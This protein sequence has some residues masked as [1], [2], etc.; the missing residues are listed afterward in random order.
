MTPPLRD[1][2]VNFLLQ[3]SIRMERLLDAVA[4]D[5][6]DQATI[7]WQRSVRL[8]NNDND[9][10]RQRARMIL[11]NPESDRKALLNDYEETLS[12]QGSPKTGSIHYQ[13]LCSTCH[14]LNGKHG[15]AIGPDLASIR[16]RTDR[17][18]MADIFMPNRSIADGYDLWVVRSLDGK[19]YSG[20][21]RSESPNAIQLTDLSGENHLIP[22]QN[23]EQLNSQTY[24]A[25]PE[26]LEAA[27][28]AQGMADLISFIREGD[29]GNISR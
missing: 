12:L 26:G 22:R 25:M 17:S 19:Q 10:I 9:K 28:D 21:I 27:L 5:K 11:E 23:I 2:A 20:I 16:N 8:L 15:Q 7:G 18:I 14:Q 3:D 24:S 29:Q 13:N 1:Q 4:E 6:I